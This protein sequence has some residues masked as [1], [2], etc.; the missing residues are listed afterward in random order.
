M[1]KPPEI[2]GATLG[3]GFEGV[4]QSS[5]TEEIDPEQALGTDP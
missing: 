3:R 1:K 5:P 4:A 2:G